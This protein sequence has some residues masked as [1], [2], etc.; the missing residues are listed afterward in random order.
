MIGGYYGSDHLIYDVSDP[1]HPRLLCTIS[2]T[3]AHLFTG[4][5][6]AYLKPVSASET[7][8]FLHS[9]G[10]GNESKAASFPVNLIEPYSNDIRD[11]AWTP[12]GGL[13]AYA[14]A[15]ESV[16]KVHVSLYS[17]GATRHVL[18]YGLP[19][20]DCVCRFGLPAQVLSFSPDGQYLA[21]G[22]IAGKG[23]TGINVIRVSDGAT[24]Y[25]A[26][27]GFNSALWDRVGHKLYFVGDV[28]TGTDAWTPEAGLAKLPGSTWQFLQGISPDDTQATYTAYQDL[29]NFAQPRVYT[30]DLKA[31]KA[32]LLID[33][34]RTQV[35]FVKDGWVWYL[36][37]QACAGGGNCMSGTSPTGK[38]FAMQ[39][40]TGTEQTVSFASGE[41]PL[42]G[43]SIWA[44][45]PGEYWP[46]S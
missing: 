42:Q 18:D 23:S 2:N 24:I 35:L 3:A 17:Q 1:L 33:Q 4:D 28:T 40:S 41:D 16:Y 9:I 7:D 30:Y 20:G 44:F 13:L 26:A 31:G 29:A 46:N 43:R 21:A 12:S 36:E 14:I 5:T 45:T 6:F 39:L 37:E 27:T 22:W 34:M 15:D 32:R 19:I 10:S 25:T 11:E 38:V 8:V